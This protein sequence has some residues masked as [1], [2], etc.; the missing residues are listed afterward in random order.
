MKD[1]TK[2]QWVRN[3]KDAYWDLLIYL[4]KHSDSNSSLREIYRNQHLIRSC[5]CNILNASNELKDCSVG[6]NG[7]PLIFDEARDFCEISDY[8]ISR[9]SLQNFL[10]NLS[11]RRTL[12]YAEIALI[13]PCIEYCCIMHLNREKERI[14]PESL[15]QSLRTLDGYDGAKMA[16]KFSRT[17]KVLLNDEIY[18]RLDKESKQLYRTKIRNYAKRLKKEERQVAV[19]LLKKARTEKDRGQIGSFLFQ[20]HNNLFYFP[21]LAILTVIQMIAVVFFLKNI[22]LTVICVVPAFLS[23]KLL[24]DSIFSRIIKPQSMPK[25]KITENNCPLSLV[26]IVS[27]LSCREDA[28]ALLHRIDVLAHRIPVSKIRIG[29]LLDMPASDTVLSKEEEEVLN[30][31]KQEI[32]TRNCEN[33]RFF[34][35]VRKRIKAEREYRFEAYGR[36]Q[37]AMIDFCNLVNDQSD[38]FCLV[39]GSF[40]NA[41]YMIT[42]D[43]DTEPTPGAVESLIGFMEHPNHTPVIQED[44][45]GFCYVTRGYGAAAPRIEANPES[46]FKTPFSALLAGNSG[47]ELYKNPHFNLYQD[48]FSEGI[49][50]GKGIIHISLYKSLIGRRFSNNPILS[51]DLPEGQFLRCANL[52]DLVFFDEIPNNVISDEKRSHRWV[53]GDYQNSLFLLRKNNQSRLFC[54]KI[55]HNLLN[56]LFAA[57]C[58]ILILSVPFLGYRGL[59]TAFYWIIYPFLLQLPSAF[60]SSCK[61]IKEYCPLRSLSN[62][63]LEALLN[64]FLLPSRAVNGLDGAIRGSSRLLSGKRK[65]EWSTAATTSGNGKNVGDYFYYLRWQQ[66]GFLLLFFPE[67]ILVGALWMIGPI[68]AHHISQ[69]YQK[70]IADTKELKS[71]LSMMWGYYADLMD[72]KNHWLPPDNYQQ[73]PLNVIARR[74]SPTNIGLALLSVLGAY[75]ISLISLE[76]MLTRIERT[77][78]TLEV[79]PKWNGHLYNWYD[80]Q[81]LKVLFP[82]FISTVDCGNCAACFHTLANGLSE[83]EGER[84]KILATR[85]KTLLDNADFSRLYDNEKNLFPIG[86]DVS[87]EKMSSSYYDLY[88][89]E[90][91]LTSYYAIMKHQIPLEH[92]KRLA[93]PTNIEGKTLLVSGWSGT[94]FEYFMPHLFLPAYRRTLSGEMLKGTL[95]A[96]KKYAGKNIPWGISESGYYAFDPLLNYQYRAFG[97]PSLSLRQ[98]LSFPKIISPYSTFL[99]YP[100]FSS[101]SE[102]NK[103][104]LPKGKYGY[105]EAVDY[106]AGEENP[107]IVQSFMAHHI[108]MSF[109]SGIN[110]LI[111]KVMQQRFMNVEGEA[112]VSLLTES[113]PNSTDSY[114][115][116]RIRE[117][118]DWQPRE[119]RIDKPDPEHPKVRILS[120]GK[121]TEILSDSGSGLLKAERSDLTGYSDDPQNPEGIFLFVRHNG[122]TYG[123]TYAPL[124][125]EKASYRMFYDGYGAACYGVFGE[126]ETRT[127][128]TMAPDFPVAIKELAIKNNQMTENSFDFFLFLRPILCAR[129]D[130]EAHP[131]YKDLFLTA[132][133]DPAIRTVSFCRKANEG[134]FWFSV[135]SSVPFQF[136]V[137]RDSFG[138]MKDIASCKMNGLSKYPIFPA[139]IMKGNLEIRGRGTDT[140]RFYFSCGK[141]KQESIDAIRRIVPQ[142]FET[143]RRRYSQAFDALCYSQNIRSADR[144]VFDQIASRILLFPVK[145]AAKTK[146][147]NILPRKTLWKYGVSGDYPIL[148]LRIGSD[149]VARVGTFLKTAYLFTFAGIDVDIVIV[150]RENDGYQT[151]IRTSLE[152]SINDLDEKIKSHIFLL[153]IKSVDEYLFLQKVSALFINLERGWKLSDPH[154]SFRPIRIGGTPMGAEPLAKALGRGGYTKSGSFLIPKTDR[155]NFRPYSLILSNRRIGTLITERGLG[156]TF[157]GNASEHRI[158]PRIPGRGYGIRGEKLYA[159][160]RGKRFDLLYNA[161]VEYRRES[162]IFHIDLFGHKIKTEVFVPKLLSAKIIR[163]SVEV[164]EE[165]LPELVYEPTV[166]LGKKNTETTTRTLEENRIYFNNAYDDV[167]GK[168]VA[169]LCGVNV[170]AEGSELH[171]RPSEA[172][173]EATFVLAY[174][175]GKNSARRLADVLSVPDRIQKELKKAKIHGENYLS[176]ETPDKELN[177]FCNGLL[178][179]QIISSRILGRTGPSQP[180]GAY[181]F[182][183]QLQDA[184]SL[185]VFHPSYLRVQILRCAAHQFE[186]GDVLHWWHPRPHNQNDGIRTRFSD[187]PFW[188]VYACG[189]YY[190][191]TEDLSFFQREIFYCSAP[192]LGEKESD[193]YFVPEKSALRESVFQHALRAYRYGYQRGQHGLILFGSGD[194]NDGMNCVEPG[195]ETVWG[196]MFALICAES[197]LGLAKKMGETDAVKYMETCIRELRSSL[198]EHAFLKG[199]Y[200][201]GFRANG[202]PFNENSIDLIPQAFAQFSKLDPL[203]VSEALEQAKERLWKKD[204]KLIRLLDPPYA[205]TDNGFPG[206]IADYPPGVRENGGQYTHAGVWFARALFF[207]GQAEEATKLLSMINP[208]NHTLTPQDVNRY[209][210]EPYVLA[211]DVYSL[212]GREGFAGWTHYTGAAGWFLR[213]VTEN[214]IGITRAGEKVFIQPNLPRSWNG[215][216]AQVKI[217]NDVLKIQVERGTQTGLFENGYQTKSVTLNGSEHKI[218]VIV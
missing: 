79:L 55:L 110:V 142:N 50:C 158:T 135:T 120:N 182:R 154:R 185:A 65:L 214:L 67:T 104:R 202:E 51:H 183:D 143:L 179:K 60:I 91:R 28:D 150:Y 167:Y 177:F 35:A 63:A 39:L 170:K 140:V 56:A 190:R 159:V 27:L 174:A 180:G 93:R 64:F 128:S 206:S 204:L 94:M 218:S 25:I 123:T 70:D 99:A 14:S 125:D 215:L 36:K 162:A 211:G 147:V 46:S 98:D 210:A 40:Y 23:A 117:R 34:C 102:K 137:T 196:S 44:P 149:S 22:F 24:C 13:I 207:N 53:R 186:E 78:D 146:L 5:C 105:Y 101:L 37:G 133:F 4:T 9:S 74:T 124:F 148:A 144:L 73:E 216:K 33:N 95:I 136:D 108:G 178:Q 45:K 113:V 188:L 193:R 85:I 172:F 8:S 153:N 111:P 176:I 168:G 71:D 156:Y 145:S 194:W 191:T 213:T 3:V 30:Y 122:K 103:K 189:E 89:S 66:L 217:G 192:P 97:I 157:A 197:F 184:M 31:L 54:F 19:D 118:E 152:S 15:L 208:V 43:S 6:E 130:Y 2:K 205:R 119:I 29:L 18:P 87:E 52:S 199:K 61:K 134:E 169:V 127:T 32:L 47:T 7:I 161:S 126:F 88:A 139:L 187:D 195:A 83:I 116:H 198:N 163:I 121:M 59:F 62:A 26:T 129:S 76:E 21:M 77:I 20:E 81:T 181:G 10:D 68:I 12:S 141:T 48:L 82:K 90:A 84:P 132:E 72:E 100:W 16:E 96:Q 173:K 164:G 106:R 112:Y 75:D 160:I 171:F 212:Q 175:S 201:R 109:L 69:P 80:T 57:S 209:A 114:F 58:L 1:L 166:I 165:P 151:P 11:E 41:K 138:E 92:W 131:E 86:Y 155:Q 17:E 203:Q 107:R 38:A 49:F 200:V 115:P 42:L